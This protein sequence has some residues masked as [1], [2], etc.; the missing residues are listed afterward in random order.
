MATTILTKD[1]FNQTV[2][3][4]GTVLI[5][6]W[7][8]WCGPCRAFAP[9]FERVS[10]KHP[11]LLFAKVDTEAQRELAATFQISSIPTLM[12]LRD[13]VLVFNQAGMLPERALEGLIDQVSKLDMVEVLK[14]TSPL[15]A[16][17]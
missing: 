4:Q 5:D 17:A 2:Q 10:D 11:D 3:A 15:A 13:G 6:W 7:A 8:P 12:V 16:R 9:I 1:N 14:D